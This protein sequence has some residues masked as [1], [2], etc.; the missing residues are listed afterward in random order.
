MKKKINC[1]DE[2]DFEKGDT[3]G[4]LNVIDRKAIKFGDGLLISR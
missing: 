2:I 4:R 1:D 3:F